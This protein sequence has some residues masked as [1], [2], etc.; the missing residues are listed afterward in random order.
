M[1]MKWPS[2]L[3]PHLRVCHPMNTGGTTWLRESDLVFIKDRPFAVFHWSHGRDGDVPD[4]WAE[5]DRKQ[6]QHD[7]PNDPMYRYEGELRDPQQSL[8]KPS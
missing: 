1:P 3:H 2:N 4:A 7:R 8:N 6:L 5:L